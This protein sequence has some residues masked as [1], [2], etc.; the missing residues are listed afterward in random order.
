MHDVVIGHLQ[1][2][3]GMKNNWWQP[4]R[5]RIGKG[6]EEKRHAT[7]L[8]L[9]YDLVYAVV[10]AALAKNL[11]RDVSLSSF[12]RFAILFVPVWWSWIGA[13]FYATRFDTDDI[14]HR[15]L[16]AVQMVAV[17]ALAV[18]V[19]HG[20]GE[21][22]AGFALSY[23]AVRAVQVVEYLRAERY[24]AAARPLITRYK[25]G[26][27]I[28]AAIWLVSAFVPAPVR[29]VLWALGLTVDFA[30]PISAGQL[31][32]QLAP[33]TSHLPERFGLFTLIVL[34]EVIAAVVDGVTE[35]KWNVQS[36]IAA[37]FGLSIAFSL[38]WVYFDG[39]NDVAI[40]AAHEAGRVRV[41]Q[42]W[43]YAHLPLTIGLTATAVG[44]EHVVLS[45]PGMLPD[46]SRWLLCSAVALCLLALGVIHLTA[47][48]TETKPSSEVKAAYRIGTA[49]VVVVLAVAG[50]GL[51]AVVLIGLVAVACAV[52][53]VLDLLGRSRSDT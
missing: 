45:A 5:L 16:T 53:V 13:A 49:F 35:Q 48:T 28:A 42:I 40:R 37:V 14:G 34:G 4:P 27:A 17:A 31:H 50:V 41:Y 7:W 12:F 43:L 20:L 23:A 46:A 30:T 21:S 32:S 26:F 22:S 44:L 9:F 10:L 38:W 18:N 39:I 51:L 3:H 2:G 6:S 19:H 1:M 25:R 11:N 52:Q 33:D 47:V 15:L 29:F 24:V 36:A 8:E